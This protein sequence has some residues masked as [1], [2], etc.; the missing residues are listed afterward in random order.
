MLADQEY[1]GLEGGGNNTNSKM[2]LLIVVEVVVVF[3]LVEHLLLQVV[4]VDQV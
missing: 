1:L 2:V 3:R 4:L